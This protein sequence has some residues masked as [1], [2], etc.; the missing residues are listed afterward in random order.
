MFVLWQE[1]AKEKEGLIVCN[2]KIRSFRPNKCCLCVCAFTWL[3]SSHIMIFNLPFEWL[4][5]YQVVCSTEHR[6]VNLFIWFWVRLFFPRRFSTAH[7]VRWCIVRPNGICAARIHL[8]FHSLSKN[9]TFS[10]GP[11]MLWLLCAF[12]KW[13]KFSHD[14]SHAPATT[15]KR[16]PLSIRGHN[17]FPIQ[18]IRSI[19]FPSPTRLHPF[20]S[21]WPGHRL[22]SMRICADS[23]F[24]HCGSTRLFGSSRIERDPAT[25]VAVCLW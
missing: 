9:V 19:L 6:V 2:M 23:L 14:W 24:T 15:L 10:T 3:T 1:G 22:H 12:V 21:D 25:S 18:L 4:L 17:S 11:G 16:T 7:I 20:H 13:W 5:A 8:L